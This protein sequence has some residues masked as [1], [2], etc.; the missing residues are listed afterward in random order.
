[1]QTTTRGLL[2]ASLIAGLVTAS[3]SV[4]QPAGAALTHTATVQVTNCSD[5]GSGSLPNA[6]A[7]APA[8]AT[9]T[10]ATSCPAANPIT[11]TDGTIV[12]AQNLDIRGP[13]ASQLVVDGANLNTVFQIDANNA[14]SISGITIQ[15]G[16]DPSNPDGAGGVNNFG[17][18]IITNCIVSENT[19]T[20]GGGGINNFGTLTAINDTVSNN[21]ALF[22][23]GLAN[24]GTATVIHSL[25]S[26]D[27]ATNGGGGIANSDAPVALA[28]LTVIDTV[29]L[30][31]TAD[32]GSG[33]ANEGAASVIF[34]TASDNATTGVG[35]GLFN[36][37]N[38]NG[39]VVATLSVAFSQ[40]SNNSATQGGAIFNWN[41]RR[42]S[43][44]APSRAILARTPRRTL[45][46]S[47]AVGSA[48]SR[49]TP[50]RRFPKHLHRG[51][52]KVTGCPTS[53][54]VNRRST[55]PSTPILLWYLRNST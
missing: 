25:I 32:W 53:S 31:N 12:I 10:F 30:N 37:S 9:V 45:V 3:M 50:N 36:E 28:T 49:L 34:S 33:I 48:R 16:A 52:A 11:L 27:T 15:D 39:T 26:S 22:G 18:L 6:V 8:G 20:Y 14:V 40:L 7:T 19:A 13:G 2:G 38:S 1:M 17:S 51:G 46:F 44:R 24:E 41:A 54:R 35:G 55:M 29:V 43:R 47:T 21:A 5:S 42:T 4:I 23:G